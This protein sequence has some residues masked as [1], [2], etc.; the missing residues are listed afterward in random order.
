MEKGFDQFIEGW[1]AEK[2]YMGVVW[3]GARL[4]RGYGCIYRRVLGKGLLGCI[5]YNLP[6]FATLS[7]SLQ[8]LYF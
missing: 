6:F 4:W 3:E 7:R 5:V 2:G 8:K 1:V